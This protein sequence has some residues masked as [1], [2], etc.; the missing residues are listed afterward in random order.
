M[1]ELYTSLAV[2]LEHPCWNAKNEADAP[3][4]GLKRWVF[5]LSAG[6]KIFKI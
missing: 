2:F 3:S 5:G 6:Q 1:G 4:E